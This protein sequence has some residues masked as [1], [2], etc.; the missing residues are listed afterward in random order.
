MNLKIWNS[1]DTVN[2]N[3]VQYRLLLCYIMEQCTV[4]SIKEQS[5]N[6]AIAFPSLSKF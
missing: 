5:R 1:F 4:H 3:I 2:L 6:I